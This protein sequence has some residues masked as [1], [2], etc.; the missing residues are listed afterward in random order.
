MSLL[1][2]HHRGVPHLLDDQHRGVAVDGLVDGHHHAHPHQ[3]L[4]QVGRLDRHPLRQIADGDRLGYRDVAVSRARRASGSHA[5]ARA[6]PPAPRRS[7][8]LRLGWRAPRSR[9]TCSSRRAAS[10]RASIPTSSPAHLPRSLR[11]PLLAPAWPCCAASS[12]RSRAAFI[13]GLAT[14]AL[15]FLAPPSLL[16]ERTLP[17]LFLR[18]ALLLFLLSTLFLRPP[19]PLVDGPRRSASSLPDRPAPARAASASRCASSTSVTE[20]R[21][22]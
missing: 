10:G 7:C 8:T 2:L 1:A 18:L 3:R 20:L 21:L 17:R 4:D 14:L 12:S 13:L 19:P 9:T 5:A 16:G 22:T 11:A 6:R 15:L